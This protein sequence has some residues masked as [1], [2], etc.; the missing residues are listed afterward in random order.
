ME[1][2]Q[3]SFFFTFLRAWKAATLEGV[4]AWCI[5][6]E[7]QRKRRVLIIGLCLTPE[8]SRKKNN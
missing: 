1:G 5:I 7:K 2:A 8:S 6:K 4:A 3:A